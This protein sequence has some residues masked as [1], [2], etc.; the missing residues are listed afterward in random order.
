MVGNLDE[1]WI[2]STTL[3]NLANFRM[4]SQ[5]E[6]E[7]HSDGITSPVIGC[8]HLLLRVVGKESERALH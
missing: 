5:V 4:K 8:V 1:R 3:G 6:E 7:K 2:A